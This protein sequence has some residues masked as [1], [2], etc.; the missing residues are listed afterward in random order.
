MSDLRWCAPKAGPGVWNRRVIYVR[1]ASLLAALLVINACA[2]RPPVETHSLGAPDGAQRVLIATEQTP[3]KQAV[4]DQVLMQLQAPS[5]FFRVIDVADLHDED[6]GRYAAVAIL[7]SC[8]A[9]HLR[10]SVTR[11]LEQ[12]PGRERIVLL[13]T[14]ANPTWQSGVDGVDAMTGASQLITADNAARWLAAAIEARLEGE[15]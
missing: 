8:F 14:A 7:N 3:F 13:T 15:R 4:V 5:R 2:L 6:A 10:P 1:A 9:W 12:T 11:F